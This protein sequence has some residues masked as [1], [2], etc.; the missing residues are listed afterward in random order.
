MLLG[1]QGK[2]VNVTFIVRNDYPCNYFIKSTS[3]AR[4]PRS[5][6][7]ALGLSDLLWASSQFVVL[8]GK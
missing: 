4:V 3:P 7:L 1:N 5:K 8:V 6:M 2:H